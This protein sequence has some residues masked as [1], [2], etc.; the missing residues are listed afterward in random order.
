MMGVVLLEKANERRKGRMILVARSTSRWASG[1]IQAHPLRLSIL[2][3]RQTTVLW[4][5]YVIDLLHRKGKKQAA[6]P[7]TTTDSAP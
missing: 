5:P 4:Q 7:P 3:P 1:N 2:I 6:V